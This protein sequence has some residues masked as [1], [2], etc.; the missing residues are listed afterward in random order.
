MSFSVVVLLQY[1]EIFTFPK[2]SIFSSLS[3]RAMVFDFREKDPFLYL[4]TAAFEQR[5]SHL[6]RAKRK[7]PLGSHLMP[8]VL[9]FVVSEKD[10][11]LIS[12]ENHP[13]S[14]SV[15][16]NALLQTE[17]ANSLDKIRTKFA[18]RKRR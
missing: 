8:F 3:A 16:S 11:P 15:Y 14:S 9:Y 17:G 12:E 6:K 2:T 4:K 13:F 10:R 1:Y 5:C 7:D 18:L